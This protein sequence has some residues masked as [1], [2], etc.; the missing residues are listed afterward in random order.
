MTPGEERVRIDYNPTGDPVIDEI[1]RKSADLIDLCLAQMRHD[2]SPS[3]EAKYWSEAN[4]RFSLA[5]DSYELG[6]VWACNGVTA[7]QAAR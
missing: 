6:C 3:P 4:R 7:G 5:M 1:K 2:P